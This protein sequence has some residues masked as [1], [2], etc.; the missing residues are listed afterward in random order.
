MLAC[1]ILSLTLAQP[2]QVVLLSE[3]NPMELSVEMKQFLDRKVDRGLPQM[4]RLQALVAAVF[5]D[6]ELNFT[7]AAESRTAIETFAK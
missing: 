2:L 6:S 5:Q 3:P 1:L 4:E 7:Y